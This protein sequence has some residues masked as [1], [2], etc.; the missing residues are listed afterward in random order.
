[1]IN[2][3]ILFGNAG[4]EPQLKEF[5]DGGA[6]ANFTIA[7]TKRG[8]KDKNG[9]KTPDRTEW[10]NIVVNGNLAKVCAQYINKG[11]K[12][13][14]DGEL[15]TRSYDDK[16]GQKHYVTEIVAKEVQFYG[17]N[18][19]QQQEEQQKQEQ[20]LTFSSQIQDLKNGLE[21]LSENEP[22]PF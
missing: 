11:D 22:M 17:Q 14:I 16:N 7:T 3:V 9:Q 21:A 2:K 5:G 10:H 19:T 1:M 20:G 18:R 6:V 13:Y 15:R 4:K 12:V 8:K